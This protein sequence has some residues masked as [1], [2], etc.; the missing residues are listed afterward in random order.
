MDVRIFL[1]AISAGQDRRH[2]VGLAASHRRNA[3]K[4]VPRSTDVHYVDSRTGSSL[5][6]S[7]MRRRYYI[8]IVP[9]P[10]IN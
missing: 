1:K 6:D 2:V 8:D 4:V 10:G 7:Q 3:S 9:Q 5:C